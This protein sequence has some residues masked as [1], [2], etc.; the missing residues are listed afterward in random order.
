MDWKI[1]RSLVEN[2]IGSLIQGKEV[3]YMPQKGALKGDR[4]E[5]SPY[6]DWTDSLWN[7]G[8]SIIRRLKEDVFIL[9]EGVFI[10][11]FNKPL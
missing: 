5:T 11:N 10:D 2:E 8:G 4:E 7:T 9:S 6:D 3:P 1:E